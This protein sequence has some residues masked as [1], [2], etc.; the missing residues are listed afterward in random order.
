MP[1]LQNYPYLLS[2]LIGAAIVVAV[3]LLV[4]K[5]RRIMLIGGAA[6]V[7]FSFC[8]ILHETSY[9]NAGRLG[10]FSWGIE[11]AL[12][13]FSV[14][15][16]TAAIGARVLQLDLPV[17]IQWQ[18]AAKKFI[19]L[20]FSATILIIM[21]TLAGMDIMFAT[22]I[23]QIAVTALLT[24]ANRHSWWRPSLASLIYT[25]YYTVMLYIFFHR[26]G[27]FA[28]LWNGPHLWPARIFGLPLEEII[29][30]FTFAWCWVLML[31][32]CLDTKISVKEELHE[33]A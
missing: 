13:T 31:A 3:Y 12:F 16:L 11:D 17:R 20:C 4:S 15:S 2:T 21:L 5:E 10:G 26:V 9:W 7:P 14:G 6:L 32:F 19:L 8:A 33:S 28:D 23:A 29:W 30:V 22:I 27:G 25:S 24:A 1:A 18:S